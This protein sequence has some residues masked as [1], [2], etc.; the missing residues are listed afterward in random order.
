MDARMLLLR[1]LCSLGALLAVATAQRGP[2]IGRVRPRL[3]G[4]IASSKWSIGAET[5]D[6]NLTVFADYR[7]F[8]P[9]LGA[10]RARLQCGWGRCILRP[11]ARGEVAKSGASRL[12]LGD[13]CSETGVRVLVAGDR[14]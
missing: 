1:V 3:S 8:L 6:R 14:C 4:E 12:G 5:Q 9:S 13:R 10:K 11:A 7:S 2:V